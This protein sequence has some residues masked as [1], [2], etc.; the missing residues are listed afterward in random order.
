MTE[1]VCISLSLPQSQLA[2]FAPLLQRGI[3]LRARVGGNVLDLLSGQFGI[4]R[5]YVEERITTLFVNS[6]AIDGLETT[7][8]NDGSV[9]ALSAAMPGLVGATMRRGGRLAAMRG[10]MT[11]RQEQPAGTDATGR[12]RIK[13]FNMVLFELGSLF[14]GRGFYLPASELA[15]L[16]RERSANFWQ[17]LIRLEWNETQIGREELQERTARLAPQDEVL[18]Q[19]EFQD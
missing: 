7:Y 2:A 9:L 3:I 6:K 16:L 1:P 14:L 8:V 18:L 17:S 10:D 13:L 19:V 15:E 12:V 11:Y 4:D 5:S